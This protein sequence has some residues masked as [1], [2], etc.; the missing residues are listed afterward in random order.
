MNRRQFVSRV[1]LG[2]AAACTTFARPS[3][4]APSTGQ[5]TLRFVGMM[6]FIERQD[7][8]F[9]VATPGQHHHMTHV[10]FLM[11]RA[12][13]RIAKALQ[14]APVP[15]VIPEAFDTTLIG[16]RPEDFVFRSLNNTSLDS[17]A[18]A[19]WPRW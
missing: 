6:G 3:L 10:P 13:S 17:F 7:R 19:R 15:G 16:T 2:T 8:S 18:P 12:G 4:A 14:F 9:L 1:S 11:A 5:V